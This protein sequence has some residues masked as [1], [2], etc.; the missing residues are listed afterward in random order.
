MTDLKT[1]R[2]ELAKEAADLASKDEAIEQLTQMAKANKK[3]PDEVGAIQ[4]FRIIRDAVAASVEKLTKQI[5][6]AE[7]AERT[8]T[9]VDPLIEAFG[10]FSVNGDAKEFRLEFADINATINSLSDEIAAAASKLDAIEHLKQVL[11]T[12]GVSEET[13]AD[14]KAVRFEVASPKSYKLA[15]ARA[16]GGNRGGS[17]AGRSGEIYTITAAGEGFESL[18]GT[19]VGKGLDFANWKEL[20]EKT[21]PTM[22]AELEQKR[23]GTWPGS[24]GKKSNYSGSLIANKKFGVEWETTKVS[25]DSEP[26]AGESSE[27]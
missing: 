19:K 21:D 7:R 3:N 1:L 16:G 13:A 9:I 6:G 25:D 20:I 12:L 2:E 14:L 23:L 4:Q 24:L 17:R 26:E 8:K 11:S 18:V 5:E 27:D 22:Y 15:M 10:Q